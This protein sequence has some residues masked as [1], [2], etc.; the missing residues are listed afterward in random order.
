MVTRSLLG[1]PVREA[2]L[3][4]LRGRLREATRPPGLAV[5]LAGDDAASA[6]YVGRKEKTCAALGYHHVT[7][8]FP[9]GVTEQELL[10]C[11]RG[12]NADPAIDGILVQL[13]LPA[14]L[15]AE[16]ILRAVDPR[17]DVDGFHPENLGLLVAGR[18]RFV[19]CTPA[20][21]VRLLRHYGIATAG[22][23]VAV[24]G[25]SLIVGRPLALLLAQKGPDGDATVTVCHSA[26]PDLT[27]ETSRADILVAAMGVPR[28]LGR[29]HVASGAVV[30][31]V[32]INRQPAPAGGRPILVG[33]VD[34][35]AL[36]GW[37]AAVTPVPGGIGLVTTAMLMANTWQAMRLREARP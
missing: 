17:K 28:A 9:A 36:D 7:H 10:A 3:D 34:A 18:P 37:A 35:A 32:G 15:D 27:A 31:D 14:G 22:R 16:R 30:V 2:I 23:R 25:R 5:V 6:V 4:E 8:R 19:P 11:V 29:A 33:D 1:E 26:T 24:V 13:P 12:L 21:V 20:G